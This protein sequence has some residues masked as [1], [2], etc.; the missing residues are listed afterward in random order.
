MRWE[1][2]SNQLS[3]QVSLLNEPMG[4]GY[5]AQNYSLPCVV[6]RF[7]DLQ[8]LVQS[9]ILANDSHAPRNI[10]HREINGLSNLY[11]YLQVVSEL[12]CGNEIRLIPGTRAIPRLTRFW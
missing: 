6:A 4:M 11:T 2:Q 7:L 5:H 1:G 3:E 8:F 9:L 12:R 10:R